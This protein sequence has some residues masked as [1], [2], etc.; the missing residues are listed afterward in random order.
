MDADAILTAI[1]EVATGVTGSV[2]TVAT[3][4]GEE[5][6]GNNADGRVWIRGRV[7]P[8][9]DVRMPPPRR[10]NA[11]GPSNA[12]RAVLEADFDVRLAYSAKSLTDL[13]PDLRYA[14]RAEAAET[15]LEVGQALTYV[16][17]LA[18]TAA[19]AATG[20]VGGKLRER[21]ATVVTRED[22]TAGIYEVELRLAGWILENQA[23][24]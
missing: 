18:Q 10:T 22:W 7:R 4:L 19:A 16:G 13:R 17:N 23:T 9:I 5:T 12:S 2:R 3:T 11:V 1:R 6:H 14:L 15:A 20:L 21:A 8:Q 24:A